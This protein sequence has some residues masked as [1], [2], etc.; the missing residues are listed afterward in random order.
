M[1]HRNLASVTPSC[2]LGG[3]ALACSM[4]EM[5]NSVP[6]LLHLCPL[7]MST[8]VEGHHENDIASFRR[9]GLDLFLGICTCLS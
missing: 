6:Y 4:D 5:L 2:W 7:R 8:D 3:R 9:V 1:L